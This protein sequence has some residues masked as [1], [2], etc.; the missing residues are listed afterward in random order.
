MRSVT[1]AGMLVMMSGVAVAAP[2]ATKAVIAGT[3]DAPTLTY[4]GAAATP[5]FKKDVSLSME[6]RCPLPATRP[7]TVRT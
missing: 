5:G 4:D 3:E 6:S 7:S 2:T 1:L